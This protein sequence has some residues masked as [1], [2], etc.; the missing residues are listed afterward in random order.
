LFTHLKPE[1]LGHLFGD[2]IQKY[3]GQSMPKQEFAKT[4]I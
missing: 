3:A 2:V 4:T 1:A